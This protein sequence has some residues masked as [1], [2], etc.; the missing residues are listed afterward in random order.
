MNHHLNSTPIFSPTLPRFFLDLTRTTQRYPRGR[1]RGDNVQ[2]DRPADGARI[3]D[4]RIRPVQQ[5][6][7]R[8]WFEDVCFHAILLRSPPP[9]L[10]FPTPGYMQAYIRPRQKISYKERSTDDDRFKVRGV[11]VQLVSLRFFNCIGRARNMHT[12]SPLFSPCPLT[13]ACLPTTHTTTTARADTGGQQGDYGAREEARHRNQG[14]RP[15]GRTGGQFVWC[16]FY[17]VVVVSGWPFN[18]VFSGRW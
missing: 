9:P 14:P 5:G 2:R 15:Y 12:P 10:S 6:T 4:Q 7:R 11:A 18:K 17:S 8:D 13:N 16:C 1:V 3:G